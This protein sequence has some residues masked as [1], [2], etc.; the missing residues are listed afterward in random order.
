MLDGKKLK[1]VYIVQ[2]VAQGCTLPP[3]LFKT[4]IID[5]SSRSSKAGSH[6]KGRYGVGID[7]CGRRRGDIRNTRRIAETKREGARKRWEM[8]GGS[9]KSTNKCAVVLL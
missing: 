1:Y 4:H 5:S 8:E 3:N 9:E 6:G 2:G 7:V